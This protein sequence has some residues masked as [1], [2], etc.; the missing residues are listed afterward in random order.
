MLWKCCIPVSVTGSMEITVPAS[1]HE[2]D[3]HLVTDPWFWVRQVVVT[4]AMNVT[5]YLN[6]CLVIRNASLPVADYVR[7]QPNAPRSFKI[8]QRMRKTRSCG[9]K[10]KMLNKDT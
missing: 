9:P 2:V 8:T 7:N 10:C 5:I 6:H 3:V 4:L 1:C